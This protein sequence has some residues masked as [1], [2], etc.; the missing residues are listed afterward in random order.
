MGIS[1]SRDEPIQHG[2]L[3]Q[4][5][6]VSQWR[7]AYRLLRYNCHLTH[8]EAR[9]IFAEHLGGLSYHRN[10]LH[11]EYKKN[12][13]H[14]SGVAEQYALTLRCDSVSQFVD[15]L[16]KTV[17]SEDPPLCYTLVREI[18]AKVREWNEWGESERLII[19]ESIRRVLAGE[20]TSGLKAWTDRHLLTYLRINGVA[21]EV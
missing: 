10:L 2:R 9:A 7:R 21:L 17:Y 4:V 12:K 11:S 3:V 16:I 18:C 19:Q 6:E 13:E 20:K 14:W 1:E 15:H 8:H 5:T